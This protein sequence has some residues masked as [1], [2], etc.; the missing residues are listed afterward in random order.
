MIEFQCDRCGKEIHADDKFAGQK[1][2]CSGCGGPILVPGKSL[3][4][5]DSGPLGAKSGKRGQ[6]A[7]P[8]TPASRRRVLRL[9]GAMAIGI[10]M[11]LIL[12]GWLLW[13][14]QLHGAPSYTR[15]MWILWVGGVFFSIGVTIQ[16]LGRYLE[17]R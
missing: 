15:T 1:G 3:A 10:A 16:W 2:L 14:Q 11:I 7:I 5:T 13:I 12:V 6:Q 8:G 17:H 4:D 9:I